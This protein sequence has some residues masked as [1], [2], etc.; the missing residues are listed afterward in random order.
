MPSP[1][2]PELIAVYNQ[3]LQSE[4]KSDGEHDG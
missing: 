4:S 2:V 1:V 3:L